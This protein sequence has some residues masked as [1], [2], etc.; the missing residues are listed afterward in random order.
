MD[1]TTHDP[2]AKLAA[3][4][5]GVTELS[6]TLDAMLAH[7]ATTGDQVMGANG[8]EILALI[9]RTTRG[10]AVE[11]RP[12]GPLG[13]EELVRAVRREARVLFRDM[14]AVRNDGDLEPVDLSVH[15]LGGLVTAELWTT[16]VARLPLVLCRCAA[17]A[18]SEAIALRALAKELADFALQ[19]GASEAALRLQIA[20]TGAP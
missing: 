3:L 7:E 19:E 15:W 9:A 13:A 20:A 8:R 10:L 14:L 12:D 5:R 1:T 16:D 18:P 17:P 6:A 2:E 11:A 4:H